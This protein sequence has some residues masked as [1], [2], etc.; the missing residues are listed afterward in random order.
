MRLFTGIAVDESAIAHLA[1]LRASADLKWTRPE[2]LHI[3]TKFIGEWPEPR[4]GELKL[5]LAAVAWP[6]GLKLVISGYTVLPNLLLAD[7]APS[8]ELSVLAKATEDALERLG[9]PPEARPY[10]PHI[11]LARSGSRG[12]PSLRA[13]I[14]SMRAP[15]GNPVAENF[16]LYLSRPGSV[17][18]TLATYP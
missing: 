8:P 2:N 4:L 14:A 5:A 6:G 1:R 17:Y 18:T 11:T 10:R 15:F 7:I 16:H 9:C 12:Y 3:T 13:T